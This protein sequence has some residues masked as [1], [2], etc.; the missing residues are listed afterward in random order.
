MPIEN[1]ELPPPSDGKALF[2]LFVAVLLS[3]L[4]FQWLS[5]FAFLVFV[6]A[7]AWMAYCMHWV[8]PNRYRDY[9]DDYV[10]ALDQTPTREIVEALMTSSLNKP[11]KQLLFDYLNQK[12]PGWADP[13]P[14]STATPAEPS[15]PSPKEPTP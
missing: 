8:D 14:S 9:R 1:F 10:Q 12:R 4:L 2:G 13:A 5:Y 7:F 6:P 3:G 11:T 15:T